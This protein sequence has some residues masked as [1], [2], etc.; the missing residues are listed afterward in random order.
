MAARSSVA[1][2]L[3]HVTQIVEFF[4]GSRV[5]DYQFLFELV[6]RLMTPG[7]LTGALQGILLCG[8]GLP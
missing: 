2:A 4:R 3:A 6:T 1:R 5:E 8:H 7:H